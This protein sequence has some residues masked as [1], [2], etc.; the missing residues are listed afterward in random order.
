MLVKEL[1][2]SD[3]LRAI[4]SC[5]VTQVLKHLTTILNCEKLHKCCYKKSP[6]N[7]AINDL[8][9]IKIFELIHLFQ[10][11]KKESDRT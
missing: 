9:F 1:T 6:K 2:I 4:K 10:K 7:R 5:F 3:A 11:L 8:N